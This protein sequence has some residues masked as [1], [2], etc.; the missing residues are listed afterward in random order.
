VDNSD[1]VG[2]R[3]RARVVAGVAGDPPLP[4][5]GENV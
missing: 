3:D 5:D 2:R 1:R 4:Q